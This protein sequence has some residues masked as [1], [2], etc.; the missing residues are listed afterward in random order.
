MII[1]LVISIHYFFLRDEC[2]DRMHTCSRSIQ[3][4]LKL[5]K[6][7]EI[8]KNLQLKYAAKNAEINRIRSNLRRIKLSKSNLEAILREVKE[9]KLISEEGHRIM[10]VI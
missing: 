1:L 9:K 8:I 2:D 7:N 6:A 3:L 10:K 5:L 4:E